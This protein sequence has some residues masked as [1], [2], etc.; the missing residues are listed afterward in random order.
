[1]RRNMTPKRSCPIY[2][3]KPCFYRLCRGKFWMI[4]WW[5]RKTCCI[6]K[7]LDLVRRARNAV[8]FNLIRIRTNMS[9]KT[10]LCIMNLVLVL[11]PPSSSS[12]LI[13]NP[14]CRL[15][16]HAW[17]LL[18]KVECHLLVLHH[19]C[20]GN[21]KNIYGLYEMRI[22]WSPLVNRAHA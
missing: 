22:E 6:S 2:N 17:H 12:Y 15:I 10:S 9:E 19:N 4:D 7:R 13:R 14:S 20:L 8:V 18:D 5:R 1:M 21:E 3:W 16:E 11:F